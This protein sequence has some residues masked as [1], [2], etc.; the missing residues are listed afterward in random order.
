MAP[1]P[2]VQEPR[3]TKS[4][5]DS[6]TMLYL[7]GGLALT[8]VGLGVFALMVALMAN[9]DRV[10]IRIFIIPVSIMGAGIGLMLK[11]LNDLWGV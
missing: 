8:F 4:L 3:K 7:F 11:S 5:M 1:K 2:V 6:Q 9:A 10:R